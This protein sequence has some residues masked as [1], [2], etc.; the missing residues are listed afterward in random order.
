MDNLSDS[1][2]LVADWVARSH[3]WGLHPP[4]AG[5]GSDYPDHQPGDWS[6]SS[7]GRNKIRVIRG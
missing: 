1:A 2:G 6:K 4:A 3:R 5:S 7:L